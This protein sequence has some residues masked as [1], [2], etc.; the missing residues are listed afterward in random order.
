MES[1]TGDRHTVPPAFDPG[2]GG[3]RALVVGVGPGIGL[4]TAR[5]LDQLGC[6]IGLV[7]IDLTRAETA[8]SA[9]G[10]HGH[11][12]FMA[13]VRDAEAVASLVTAVNAQLG[14][15]D[16]LVNVVGI[17]GPA[18]AVADM[19]PDSFDE[20]LG[21][22][23]RQQFLVANGFLPG[24]I[25][26]KHGSIVVISSIN[27]TASSPQRAAYGIA[28]AGLDSLV[29]TMAIEGAPHGVRANSV[30]P[31]ATRTPRRQHLSEGALGELY[32]REIPIGR[33]GEPIDV[34]NLVVFL[35]SDLARHITGVHVT[36]DGG[37]TIRYSQPA[38]NRFRRRAAIPIR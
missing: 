22:N 33:L 21:L 14:P 25:D 16:V 38:G 7:D 20:V 12:T 3:R 37:S 4:E 11:H 8:R 5:L 1:T 23:L 34:A 36:I 28:K 17:G 31:G 15:V 32:Q 9:L 29:R 13:D 30:R 10:N 19:E 6:T 35:A 24:M 27:A 26:R 2:L 18:A